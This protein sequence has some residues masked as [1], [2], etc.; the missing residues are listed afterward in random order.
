MG[1]VRITVDGAVSK[2]LSGFYTTAQGFHVLSRVASG[3]QN[4]PHRVHIELLDTTDSGSTG[5]SFDL[6]CVGTGGMF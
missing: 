3:L 2:S 6:L 5:K 4:G 1:Q